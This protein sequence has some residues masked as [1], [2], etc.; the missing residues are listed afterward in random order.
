LSD[1]LCGVLL[2]R[3]SYWQLHFATF[4]AASYTIVETL[5]RKYPLALE[6]V[7]DYG[8]TPRTHDIRKLDKKTQELLSNNAPYTSSYWMELFIKE[9]YEKANSQRCCM[10]QKEMQLQKLQHSWDEMKMELQNCKASNS[11]LQSRIRTL[12]DQQEER[13]V[14]QWKLE[15]LSSSLERSL[16]ESVKIGVDDDVTLM[17]HNT[18]SMHPTNCDTSEEQDYIDVVLSDG[19]KKLEKRVAYLEEKLSEALSLLERGI[20]NNNTATKKDTVVENGWVVTTNDD[21]I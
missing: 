17:N 7:N 4:Y 21:M 13:E 18:N 6:Q 8:V 1:R 12:E 14:L 9:S 10:K 20:L 16:A 15:S 2:H 19:T 3:R 5:I 11:L